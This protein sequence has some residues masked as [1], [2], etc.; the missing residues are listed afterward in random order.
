MWPDSLTHWLT[1]WQGH[2]LSCP[3]QLKNWPVWRRFC[4]GKS[5]LNIFFI[6]YGGRWCALPSFLDFFFQ[7]ILLWDYQLFSYFLIILWDCYI[8]LTYNLNSSP[9]TP[10]L[11]VCHIWQTV[12]RKNGGVGQC[13][14]VAK[15]KKE[16]LSMIGQKDKRTLHCTANGGPCPQANEK[17]MVSWRRPCIGPHPHL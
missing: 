5:L 13:L 14:S 12:G 11:F 8:A 15:S 4:P 3:G 16:P 2:L 17:T 1:E 6:K 7:I 9:S 10:F